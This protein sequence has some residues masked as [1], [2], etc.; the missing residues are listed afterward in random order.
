[1]GRRAAGRHPGSIERRRTASCCGAD[2]NFLPHNYSRGQ[3]AMDAGAPALAPRASGAHFSLLSAD[4]LYL[5]NQGTHVKLYD[6]LGA[7][8]STVDGDAGT[9]FA[10]WAPHARDL[11]VEAYGC[12]CYALR[13]RATS[14]IWEGFI[15][16]Q[17]AGTVYNYRVISQF[18][19]FQAE[20]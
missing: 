17:G 10:V 9:Q 2:R 3:N 19:A 5:F 8:Q 12:G 4:D 11:N 14:G 20:K 7:H 13:P 6:K 1:M 15:P 18:G 16:G